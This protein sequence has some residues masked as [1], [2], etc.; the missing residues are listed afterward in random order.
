[1]IQVAGCYF[2][3]INK[4]D[5]VLLMSFFLAEA[6]L[7]YTIPLVFVFA[8]FVLEVI[9]MI[10]GM[11]VLSVFSHILP[12]PFNFGIELPSSLD[13][14]SWFYVKGMPF[15]I[16]LIVLSTL[17]GAIGLSINYATNIGSIP[18]YTITALLSISV[19][20]FVGST[21]QN[22]IPKDESSSVSPNSFSGKIATVTVGTSSVGRPAEA[23]LKDEFGQ[24]HYIMVVPSDNEHSFTQGMQ[25]IVVE[26]TDNDSSW[27]VIPFALT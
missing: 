9:G 22:A 5:F 11:S 7:F 19:F 27:N 6:N 10:I 20:R 13:F 17:W 15:L 16:S 14:L 1:M 3:Y 4:K 18:S 12:N 2:V 21:L 26:K 8:V 23:M 24:S 25:V